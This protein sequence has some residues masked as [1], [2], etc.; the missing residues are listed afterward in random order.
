[1]SC[2]DDPPHE[3]K[4]IA[5][6][7]LGTWFFDKRSRKRKY[8]SLSGLVYSGSEAMLKARQDQYSETHPAQILRRELMYCAV[9]T[10]SEKIDGMHDNNYEEYLFQQMQ[11]AF[12]GIPPKLLS[13]YSS[14]KIFS[15]F[16]WQ[17]ECLSVDDGKV[18]Y[19]GKNL[20]YSAPT[21]G[22]KT[23]VAEIL[24]L[25]KL[26]TTMVLGNPKYVKRRTIMFVVPF[27][28]LAEEKYQYFQEVWKDLNLGIKCFHQGDV[29]TV[30]GE[31]V[32]VAIVTI[33]RA[34]ILF[35]QLLEEN[36]E[37]QLSMIVI[38]EIHL[39]SDRHRGFL[40]E[41]L[42]TKL[43]YVLKS[44]IQIIGMSATLPNIKDLAVWLDASLFVTSY[45]PV[46]LQLYVVENR[47]LFSI[48]TR[49]KSM[50][51]IKSNVE[52]NITYE[53][54]RNIDVVEDDDMDG[55]K[56]I[57]FESVVNNVSTLVFCNSKRRCE[58]CALNIT[59]LLRAHLSTSLDRVTIE[60]R[61]EIIKLLA[62][63]SVGLCQD[64]ERCIP[65][66]VAFHHAGLSL[67][68][69][70]I[71]ELGFRRGSIVLLCTTSTLSAGVNLPARRVIIR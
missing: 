1:M 19:E 37:S 43:K 54:Y 59:A 31:D 20:I 15:L 10:P 27:V 8:I 44:S 40:L 3:A 56:S 32:E 58:V 35:N 9:T 36:R 51:Q 62:E 41:V 22:G 65:F 21:S 13:R 66:G 6:Q 12:W 68:E 14:C 47:Q 5:R 53:F 26:A 64:L 28:A 60:A 29:D 57:A 49:D 39:L 61:Q 11:L 67:D 46:Q 30:L 23:L 52:Q 18:F 38:D 7:S 4:K 25:R 69:R 45:R 71:I 70:N 50:E 17:V 16:P 34:N 42:L 55:F 2:F 63:S 33:E 24:M 48:Q